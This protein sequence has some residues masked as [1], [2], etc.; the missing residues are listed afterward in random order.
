MDEAIFFT[1]AISVLPV[2]VRIAALVLTMPLLSGRMVG[3]RVKTALVVALAV[4]I[5]PGATAWE[6][7]P[8][9][10]PSQLV[11]TIINEALVGALMGL[12]CAVVFSGVQV[13]GGLIEG[14]CG[15][16]L[17]SIGDT[18]DGVTP[19]GPY[20]KLFWW[21][22]AAVFIATGGVGQVIEGLLFSFVVLPV[23][24]AVFDQSF[25]EFL[26]QSIGYAFEFGISA[27]LPA[28]AG[29]LVAS[30]VLGMAQRNFPQFGGLQ[31][32]LGIKTIFGMAMTSI[33]LLSAPW[34]VTGGL[35]MTLGEFKSWLEMIGTG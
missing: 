25:L 10:G 29:L 3:F 7:G 20:V 4:A 31:V 33:V 16:S 32:G 12:S 22:T 24:A 21:T 11:F 1:I 26:V 27:V 5:V 13:A 6:I 18:S 34:I 23:G 19:G 8:V 2:V 15:L 17:S 35:E 28:V 30:I 14:L 9:T